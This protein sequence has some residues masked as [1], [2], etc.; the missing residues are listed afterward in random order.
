MHCLLAA[1]LLCV[2]GA[3][4]L[5]D[6]PTIATRSGPVI[7]SLLSVGTP[8]GSVA[9]SEFLGIPFAAPPIGALRF[10][11]PAPP[12][13]W[14][15]VRNATSHSAACTQAK[16]QPASE[17]CLYL[18]V[19]TPA[20]GAPGALLPVLVWIFGGGFQSGSSSL[21]GYT[22]DILA[23]AGT[24]VVSFNYRVGVFGWGAFLPSDGA[25]SNVGLLDQQV[26]LQWVQDNIAAFGG[27][28]ARVTLFG[29]SA[30]AISISLHLVIASSQSLFAQAALESGTAMQGLVGSSAPSTYNFT[31]Q[32]QLTGAIFGAA[33]CASVACARAL[34]AQTLLDTQEAVLAA[35]PGAGF[36]PVIDGVLIVDEPLATLYAQ[37]SSASRAFGAKPLMVGNVLDEG[38]LFAPGN[39]IDLITSA[40]TSGILAVKYGGATL[41]SILAAYPLDPVD[42][43]SPGYQLAA[44]FGDQFF[45]CPSRRVLAGYESSAA[46]GLYMWN[47][48][49]R[50]S[51]INA[52]LPFFAPQ[53]KLRVAHTS[54]IWFVFG[55]PPAPV[56]LFTAAEAELSAQ[57][58]AAWVQFAT[59]GRAPWPAWSTAGKAFQMF[60]TSDGGGAR[61]ERDFR[62]ARC[63]FGDSLTSPA[64]PPATAPASA[65]AANGGGIGAGAITVI[66]LLSVSV[67]GLAVYYFAIPKGKRCWDSESLHSTK[68]LE[69]DHMSYGEMN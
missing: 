35:I 21:Y 57:M 14:S 27:D 31:V 46:G 25:A 55:H 66:S 58:R 61:L 4:A 32:R 68:F 19:W 59:T 67:A 22:G 38:T 15:V 39:D 16:R 29:E 34:S 6:S 60:N 44:A 52:V 65:P 49:H 5:P 36:V 62:G 63:N 43:T 51:W 28:R 69:A 20:T 10:A 37:Q 53:V 47:F 1:V 2:A 13:P 24:V 42:L 54:E 8:A 3:T 45:T 9:V 23:A 64:P 18:N 26:A 56:L 30:G 33:N 11:P 7:G 17:D 12:A 48:A 50:P 40:E 41:P